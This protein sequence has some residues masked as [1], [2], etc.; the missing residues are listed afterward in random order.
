MET[1]NGKEGCKTSSTLKQGKLS[2]INYF[3]VEKPANTLLLY[4]KN[5]KVTRIP[6]CSNNEHF[7]FPT[8]N[9]ITRAQRM[10]K[11]VIHSVSNADSIPNKRNIKLTNKNL[12]RAY[13]K[14]SHKHCKLDFLY[15][16]FIK[17][18]NCQHL[19][20]LTLTNN[21]GLSLAHYS[22]YDKTDSRYAET[23][24]KY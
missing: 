10:Q 18:D 12:N 22:I 13:E 2:S 19:A 20:L 21:I 7:Y 24:V 8:T 23:A 6:K 15:V 9:L 1:C 4:L 3:L 11:Y 16:I 17:A 5:I 14:K